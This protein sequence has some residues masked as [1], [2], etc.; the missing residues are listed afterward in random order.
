MRVDLLD[1]K[2]EYECSA[3]D[4]CAWSIH[5]PHIGYN[6]GKENED[7]WRNVYDVERE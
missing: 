1:G 3:K 5:A 6:Q 2:K 4:E 7:E